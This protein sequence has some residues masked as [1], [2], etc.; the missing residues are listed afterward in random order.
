[1]SQSSEA[2]P[3]LLGR[4][5]DVGRLERY[6]ASLA[7]AGSVLLMTG[8]PGVGKSV[9]L[10][11]AEGLAADRLRVLRCAGVEF[12]VDVAYSSL[13]QALRPLR[14]EIRRL[15]E[16]PR[17]AIQVALGLSVAAPQEPLVVSNG[18]LEL[19]ERAAADRPLL[20]IVD[21]A[22]WLDRATAFT[23]AF[24][25]RRLAGIRL[26]LLVA[27]RSGADNVFQALRVDRLELAPL[28]DPA[29]A[30]LLAAHF[31][32][33]KSRVRA[34]LLAEAQGNPLALLELPIQFAGSGPDARE[35]PATLPLT[36]RLQAVFAARLDELDGHT[37]EVL[38]LAALESS[39]RLDVLER[40]ASARGG[41]QSL[42][43][44]ERQRLL[45]VDDGTRSVRFRHPLV[46]GAVVGASTHAE[47]RRA[48]QALAAVFA[49]EP[50]RHVWHLAAAAAGPDADVALLLEQAAH[51][52]FRRG[53]GIGA[54]TILVRSADLSPAGSDRSHRLAEAAYIGA[55]LNGKL[56]SIAPLVEAARLADATP[57]ARLYATLAAASVLYEGGELE[58]AHRMLVS[59][60]ESH[61]GSWDETDDA[62]QA[63]IGVLLAICTFLSTPGGWQPFH[64]AMARLTRAPVELRL[65]ADLMPDPARASSE[66]VRQLDAE[67]ERL[68]DEPDPWRVAKL[69]AASY[70]VGG[71]WSPEPLLGILHR[72]DDGEP[73]PAMT[74]HA[75]HWLSVHHLRSGEWDLAHRHIDASLRLAAAL[76]FEALTWMSRTQRTLLAA[77]E[78]DEDLLAELCEEALNWA[79]PRRALAVARSAHHAAG[80]GALGRGDYGAA[81]DWLA[82]ISPPGVLASHAPRALQTGMDLVEAAV[83]S[84]RRTEA[85][86]HAAALEAAGVAAL[87]PRLALLVAASA[88]LVEDDDAAAVAAFER[89][90]ALPG[91]EDWPFDRAR[92]Q[93]SLGERLRR[94]APA[95][96]R[97]PLRAALATFELMGARPWAGRARAELLATGET[98]AVPGDGS[99]LELT[100][101]ERQIAEL[102]ASG[103]TNREIGA[104]LYLSHRTVGS[105]LHHVFPKLGITSRAAL[106]DALNRTQVDEADP[107]G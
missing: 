16:T 21:D 37:R 75:H 5:G 30:A 51:R 71:K 4:D 76:D 32:D 87:S 55:S 31:P 65:M 44:A 93:L 73:A 60:I 104:R 66:S 29:A 59:A 49:D 64:A 92:V 19:L 101:Q 61:A 36:E 89:A 8:E 45:A 84:G 11:V 103:L 68:V 20:I 97:T 14:A 52:A 57:G 42:G 58:T 18:V 33:L 99:R 78:G 26:G 47:R 41:L 54:V 80:L 6:L 1:M 86:A 90:L 88:A 40:A 98:R 95:E 56:D 35:L 7:T 23:L 53:D 100:A 17:S 82:L 83:R 25:A 27:A 38:L 62:V 10:D 43:D 67:L 3:E 72:G 85:T 63:A 69:C 24:V 9:L 48:H 106:R 77:L 102:A 74:I 39:G 46:R 15:D 13:H 105:H 91:V 22:Q 96:A 94:R 34:R 79:G 107:G 12:E 70:W 2:G 81:F 50:D 28:T